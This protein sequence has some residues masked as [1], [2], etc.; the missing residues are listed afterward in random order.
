MIDES[1][2]EEETGDRSPGAARPA[3]LQVPPTRSAGRSALAVET[4]ILNSDWRALVAAPEALAAAA[5]EAALAELRTHGL[6]SAFPGLADAT[7]HYGCRWEVSVALA[8][9]SLLRRLNRDYRN[10]DRPTNVLAFP[11]MEPGTAPLT[12]GPEESLGD[13]VLSLQAVTREAATQGKRPEH[14]LCHLL[15]HGFLHL[16]GQDHQEPAEAEAMEALEI[17]ALARLDIGNPYLAAVRTEAEAGEWA[18]GRGS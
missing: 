2:N 3:S 6:P 7:L 17:A 8:D 1:M 11:A 18:G 16:L 13:I 14:H 4:A 10:Q 5:C 9:D 12:V 15:I